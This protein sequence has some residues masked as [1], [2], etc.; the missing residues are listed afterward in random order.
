MGEVKPLIHCHCV[1]HAKREGGGPGS[2][3]N[4][5]RTKWKAPEAI[6]KKSFPMCWVGKKTASREAGNF[7]FPDFIFI[8]LECTGGG[9]G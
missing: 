1:L 6:R 7:F 3:Y 4:C 5:V 2:M 9:G 8:N